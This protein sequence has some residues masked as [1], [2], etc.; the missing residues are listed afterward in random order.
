MDNAPVH[1]G[2]FQIFAELP[3]QLADNGPNHP[4][5]TDQAL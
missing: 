5:M 3:E 4:E 2:L 1:I